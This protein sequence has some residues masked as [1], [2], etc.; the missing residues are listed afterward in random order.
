MPEA[1]FG[2]YQKEYDPSDV[3]FMYSRA[4]IG[5]WDDAIEWLRQEEGEGGELTQGEVAH[6]IADFEELLRKHVPFRDSP[7]DAYQEAKG[8]CSHVSIP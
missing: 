6:M 3:E 5:S 7:D 1:E 8:H 4:R 2:R